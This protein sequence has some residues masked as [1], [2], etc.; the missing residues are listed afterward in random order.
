MR[1]FEPAISFQEKPFMSLR[2]MCCSLLTIT[3]LLSA[4]ITPAT[5]HRRAACSGDWRVQPD[6]RG[7]GKCAGEKVS[8]RHRARKHSRE[9]AALERAAASCG[10]ALRQGQR[11]MDSGA[12][13][14]VGIR[15]AHR[16]VQRV[17]SHAEGTH[18]RTAGTRRSTARSCKSLCCRSIR[19]AIR[20]R[21]NCRRTTLI[22]RMET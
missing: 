21:N 17:I 2:S 19:P 11:G 1:R 20:L 8:R 22:P 9:H 15:R 14:G 6:I 5:E 10:L 13:E 4:Q 7:S 3:A 12:D 16:N 18:R